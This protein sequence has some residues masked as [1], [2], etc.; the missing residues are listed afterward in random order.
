MNHDKIVGQKAIQV[1]FSVL[2]LSAWGFN[3]RR[4]L[5]LHAITLSNSQP[6]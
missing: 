5:R 6:S 3:P 4:A 1:R 2:E